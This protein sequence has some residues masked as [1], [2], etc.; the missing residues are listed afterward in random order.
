MDPHR[1]PGRLRTVAAWL[2]ASPAE[3]AGLAVLLA[4]AALATALVW[5][6]GGAPSSTL[7]T[8]PV[9]LESPA[10]GPVTVHVAGGVVD[11]GV[12]RLP[13][14][15]RVADAI[16]AAGGPRFDAALDALNM[17]RVLTDGE[18]VVVPLTAGP[19]PPA[20][21][22]VEPRDADGRVDL[23]AATADDFE[24]LPGIGPVLAE[25]IVAWRDAHG[26]FADV[27]QLRDVPGI[28]ERT[29]QKLAERVFVR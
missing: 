5:W 12:V 15:A 13:G 26:P 6:S 28:G 10:P 27:G 4:G 14:G 11:P 29:F 3:A 25:R 20:P 22:A 23:N 7:A 21:T 2:D 24:E 9:S 17:A 19:G 8:A 1:S 16:A 18:Q